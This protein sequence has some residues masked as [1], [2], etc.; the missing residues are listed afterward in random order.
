[1]KIDIVLQARS[2]ST[3][4]PKKIYK[5]LLGKSMLEQIVHRLNQVSNINHLCVATIP[6]DL[7]TI[8]K[9]LKNE[10]C[11]VLA[12]SENNVLERFIKAGQSMGTDIMIRTTADNPFVD[13]FHL[14][15]G[16]KLFLKN[17]WDYFGYTGLPYGAGFEIFQFT[18]LKKAYAETKKK[19]DLEHVTPYIY[20]NKDKF[21]IE[22]RNVEKA[23]FCPDLRVTVDTLEDYE[24]AKHWYGKYWNKK[25]QTVDLRKVIQGECSK[26]N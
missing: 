8:Q 14:E 20:N 24:K 25:T 7:E 19:F 15:K 12:G 5:P 18:A 17:Q 11:L 23:Y 13:F 1:M 16:I 21:C 2:T 4:L 6:Q 3:R 26:K 9:L 10:R 22:L